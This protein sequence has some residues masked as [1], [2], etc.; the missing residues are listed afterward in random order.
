M[1]GGGGGMDVMMNLGMLR[2]GKD[3][4]V[5]DEIKALVEAAKIFGQGDF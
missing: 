1:A 2:S 3:A 4:Y 5:K